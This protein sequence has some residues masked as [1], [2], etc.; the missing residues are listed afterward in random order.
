MNPLILELLNSS[1]VKLDTGGSRCGGKY[2]GALGREELRKI[3]KTHT[4]KSLKNEIKKMKTK[5]FNISGKKKDEL[6]EFMIENGDNFEYMEVY[7]KIPKY[8]MNDDLVIEDGEEYGFSANKEK[9]KKIKFKIQKDKGKKKRKMENEEELKPKKIKLKPPKKSASKNPKDDS[10]Y[11]EEEEE[12]IYDMKDDLVIEDG[13]E[14]GFSAKK[15]KPK[16]IK[17]KKPKK[18]KLKKP[19]EDENNNNNDLLKKLGAIGAV[20]TVGA[21]AGKKLYDKYKKSQENKK[22]KIKNTHKMPDGSIHTGKTHTKDSKEIKPSQKNK[23]SVNWWGEGQLPNGDTTQDFNKFKKEWDDSGY[24]VIDKRPILSDEEEEIEIDKPTSKEDNKQSNKKFEDINWVASNPLPYEDIIP[25]QDLNKVVPKKIKLKV[26]PKI[27][28]PNSKDDEPIKRIQFKASKYYGDKKPLGALPEKKIKIK[29]QPKTIEGKRMEIK[30]DPPK[31]QLER[32]IPKPKK[33]FPPQEQKSIFNQIELSLV[34]LLNDIEAVNKSIIENSEKEKIYNGHLKILKDYYNEFGEIR[35]RL[36]TD[37]IELVLKNLNLV[38]DE[39]QSNLKKLEIDK[40]NVIINVV[41]DDIKER[42]K[43]RIR[44][45]LMKAYPTKY[46][47]QG[48]E[49]AINTN[50]Q[51]PPP[52][53]M[54]F[55]EDYINKLREEEEKKHPN[56]PIDIYEDEEEV[57]NGIEFFIQYLDKFTKG[58]YFKGLFSKKIK[59]EL[60]NIRKKIEYHLNEDL[61]KVLKKNNVNITKYNQFIDM[62]EG[63]KKKKESEDIFYEDKTSDEDGLGFFTKNYI[64]YIEGK[65][66]GMNYQLNKK[67]NGIRQMIEYHLNEELDQVLL[68]ENIDISKYDEFIKMIER[69]LDEKPKKKEKPKE[70][71]K[72]KDFGHRGNSYMFSKESIEASRKRR[73][74]YH[75]KEYMKTF[76][77]R[78]NLNGIK[79]YNQKNPLTI[80]NANEYAKEVLSLN[81]RIQNTLNDDNKIVNDNE[82][83]YNEYVDT[84]KNFNKRV[85]MIMRENVGK[86]S[87][88]TR[89][90]TDAER[91]KR[92]R[93]LGKETKKIDKREQAKA[94]YKGLPVSE[95]YSVGSGLNGL[96]K[97]QNYLKE[98]KNRGFNAKEAK[99][100]YNAIYKPNIKAIR[101]GAGIIHSYGGNLNNPNNWVEVLLN[102]GIKINGGEMCG[103]DEFYMSGDKQY[104]KEKRPMVFDR[105]PY[106]IKNNPPRTIKDILDDDKP[107]IENVA[108]PILQDSEI[109]MTDLSDPRA[110]GET[111]KNIGEG[112]YDGVKTVFSPFL[113]LI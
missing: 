49:D 29:L 51:L 82:D 63:N 17:L 83:L 53:D 68:K 66:D 84:A 96:Q 22:I 88:S 42:R 36:N 100:L 4:V 62:L 109:D 56:I 92:I 89:Y 32:I 38:S 25:Q 61:D 81:K 3:L 74:Q 45:K 59:K 14:Y 102:D 24:D 16:K 78:Y 93:K 20:G 55:E 11:E 30:K 91:D 71:E 75:I 9:P 99:L 31:L 6:I 104:K 12:Q 1:N 103:G 23:D 85:K 65:Y 50:S 79:K 46:D 40:N 10:D 80:E 73:D 97:Y 107:S 98:M 48:V 33:L 44:T 105:K 41:E 58:K 101:K 108:T 112:I 27:D 76:N 106:D 19:K 39:L 8:D 18:I 21:I 110:W 35:D 113:A 54:F 15:E 69:D 67:L 7:G 64:R 87:I 90:E 70:K 94:K 43:E 47:I 95:K 57:E 72:K 111:F 77:E 34:K 2:G 13:E 86:S 28:I 60:L 5:K 52:P 26:S 37:V